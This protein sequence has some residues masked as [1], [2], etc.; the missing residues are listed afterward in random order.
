MSGR[1]YNQIRNSVFTTK[2]AE[3]IEAAIPMISV[4]AK[5]CTGPVPTA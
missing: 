3:I 2:I 5:P 1:R 4:I